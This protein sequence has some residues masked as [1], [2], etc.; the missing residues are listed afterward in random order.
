MDW[1][2]LIAELLASGMTQQAIGTEI[3]LSQGAISHLVNGRTASV[4]WETGEKLIR[5]HGQRTSCAGS[6]TA[7]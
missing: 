4:D 5:L 7:A 3:G 6:A 1:K 2:T